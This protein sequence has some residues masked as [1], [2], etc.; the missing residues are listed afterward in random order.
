MFDMV[1]GLLL[2]V[3]IS[4][5]VEKATNTTLDASLKTAAEMTRAETAARIV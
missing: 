3:L 5:S 1:N 4:N 2:Y